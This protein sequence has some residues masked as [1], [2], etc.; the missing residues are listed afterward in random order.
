MDGFFRILENN[1]YI[2]FC[3]RLYTYHF[4]AAQQQGTPKKY[5]YGIQSFSTWQFLFG[6]STR[7]L[8]LTIVNKTIDMKSRHN[9]LQKKCPA[10]FYFFEVIYT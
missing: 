10:F 7:Y 6:C 5:Y 4:S 3:T 1:L 9:G 2:L 8:E